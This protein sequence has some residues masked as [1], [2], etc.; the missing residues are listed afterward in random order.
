MQDANRLH[1]IVSHAGNSHW[2]E[3]GAILTIGRHL[4]NDIVIAS[5]SVSRYHARIQWLPGLPE[6]GVVDLDSQNGTFVGPV[7]VGRRLTS[8]GDGGA[9]VGRDA[10]AGGVPARGRV[11]R[12]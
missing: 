5:S 10:G 3:P 8:L 2:I 7:E 12:G 9:A 11:A 6:P 1:A 4:E